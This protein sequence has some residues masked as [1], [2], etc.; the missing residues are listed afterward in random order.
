MPMEGL[1]EP[2]LR[3]HISCAL[4]NAAGELRTLDNE[5]AEVPKQRVHVGVEFVYEPCEYRGM[6]P[7]KLRNGKWAAGA[8]VLHRSSVPGEKARFVTDNPWSK[9]SIRPGSLGYDLAGEQQPGGRFHA[10]VVDIELINTADRPQAKGGIQFEVFPTAQ[11]GS[12]AT[13]VVRGGRFEGGKNGLFAPTGMSMIYAENSS[14]GRNTGNDVNQTHA[15]YINGALLSHFK[16]VLFYGDRAKG[17][18]GGHQLKDKSA[19]RI[20]ENVTLDNSG[21]VQDDSPMPLADFTSWGWTWSDGL[22]L[23]RREPRKPREALIDFRRRYYVDGR[24]L[25]LPWDTAAGWRMPTA[26]GDCS[27]DVADDVYLHVLHNTSV[28]S[29]QQEAYAVRL[30]GAFA[31]KFKQKGY[32]GVT[33][34][35]DHADVMANPRRNRAMSISFN[36]AGTI[37]TLSSP[38]GYWYKKENPPAYS[39]DD[40]EK[41]HPDVAA[42][43]SDRDAFIRH[44]LRKMDEANGGTIPLTF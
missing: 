7:G 44:A 28:E 11:S 2:Q 3:F 27:G 41:L 24:R 22:S 31:T 18:Y 8:V 40:P 15:T 9:L 36:S 30:H 12:F 37:D 38:T 16:D 32:G 13:F 35:M 33:P 10:E 4:S 23:V 39:C 43:A 5:P 26:P 21:G 34:D 29:F 19:I 6:G 42:L 1:Y 20:L 17:S 14:F 25:S